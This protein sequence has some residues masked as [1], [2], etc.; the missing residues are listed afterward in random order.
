VGVSQWGRPLEAWRPQ[1][2]VADVL[3][4]MVQG[5]RRFSGEAPDVGASREAP[6]LSIWA[7]RERRQKGR[8]GGRRSAIG[9]ERHL[10]RFFPGGLLT[11]TARA[12][13]SPCE[14]RAPRE[15]R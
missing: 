13:A 7:S 10:R 3:N 11:G 14:K 15:A 12:G 8:G 2:E 1:V 9:G 6:S 4:R 5:K